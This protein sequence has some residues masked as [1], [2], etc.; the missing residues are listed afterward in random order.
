MEYL[1]QVIKNH[2]FELPVEK[3]IHLFSIHGKKN[4]KKVE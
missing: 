1:E 4:G 2:T 3:T